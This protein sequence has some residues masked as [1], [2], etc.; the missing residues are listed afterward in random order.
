LAR[1]GFVGVSAEVGFVRCSQRGSEL[2][3]K[4]MSDGEHLVARFVVDPGSF[5]AARD[6][7]GATERAEMLGD[8]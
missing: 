7:A 3:E 5:A 8:T 6:E 4:L 1:S 2:L